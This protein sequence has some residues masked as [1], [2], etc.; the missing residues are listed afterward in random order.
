MYRLQDA[1]GNQR[2]T[3]GWLR[4]SLN[5]TFLS[6]RVS[7]PLASLFV[8]QQNFSHTNTQYRGRFAPSP[9]G[10]LHFGSLVAAL[11]SYLQAKSQQGLWFVRIEDIDKPRERPGAVDAILEGLQA[12]G[13]QWDKDEETAEYLAASDNQCLVQTRRLVRYQQ[14][15][16]ALSEAQLVYGCNCTRKQIKQGGGLYQGTCL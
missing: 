4:L 14:V 9:S 2:K 5:P 3:N 11:G 7:H 10:P 16:E 8:R 13:M 1:F 12:F 6:I 15:L